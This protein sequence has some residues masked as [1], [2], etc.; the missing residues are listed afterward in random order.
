[1]T[2]SIG[3][4]FCLLLIKKILFFQILSANLVY[5]F[6]DVKL[7]GKLAIILVIGFVKCFVFIQIPASIHA[8]FDLVVF[9]MLAM[10]IN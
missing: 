8:G 3:S 1:M 9:K 6:N 2:F 5:T 7:T 4:T 10:R